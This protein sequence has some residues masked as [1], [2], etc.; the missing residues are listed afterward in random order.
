MKAEFEFVNSAMQGIFNDEEDKVI[1]QGIERKVENTLIELPCLPLVGMAIDILSFTEEFG[2]NKT[3]N[4]WLYEGG[5]FRTITIVVIMKDR[6]K[7]WI[8]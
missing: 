5:G 2:F 1:S 6:I 7:L 3:E 4:E 8:E